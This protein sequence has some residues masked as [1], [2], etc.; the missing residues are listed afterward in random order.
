MGGATK[1]EWTDR[2]WNPVTGCTKV[3]DGCK[4]CYAEREWARL[5]AN[6]KLAAYF[7]RPFT[8]V[9]CHPERLDE[10]LRWRRPQRVFVNSMSD[11]F[12][13]SVPD[14]FIA[15]VWEIMASSTADCG[16]RH[17]HEEECWQGEPHTFQILTKRPERMRDVLER[18]GEIADEYLDPDGPLNLHF[19]AIG[20]PLRNVWLGVSAENQ[21]TADARIPILLQTPA[22]VR[23][24][25]LEP[26]LEAVSLA[27]WLD[28]CSYYCDHGDEYPE[29]HRPER[30][31]IDWVIVGGESGPN[32]RP[33]AAE[34]IRDL[35]RQCKGAGVPCFVKQFGALCEM[36]DRDMGLVGRSSL[37]GAWGP[38]VLVNEFDKVVRFPGKGGDPEE[39]PA[40]CRVREYPR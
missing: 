14:E 28:R 37:P 29:G 38:H 22:A 13:E 17:R 5:S 31:P 10:P 19:A 32:A 18:M 35:L 12:H 7:G 3:S 2:T 1:I 4:N 11:L 21:E 39:W 30:S 24:V 25:S 23:F 15:Q 8:E 33:C 40:D 6:P 26:L 36:S 34:D 20:G 16:K 9:R 27:T